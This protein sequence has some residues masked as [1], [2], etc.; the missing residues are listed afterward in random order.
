MSYKI[1]PISSSIAGQIRKTMVSPFGNLPAWS[2]LA[3]GYGPCRTCLKTFTVGEEERIYVT[4]NP[5]AEASNLPL[6][7]PIFIHTSDCLEYSDKGFP[8]ELLE[9]PMLLEGFGDNSQLVVTVSVETERVDEQIEEVLKTDQVNF[10][11][12]RNAEAGCFIAKIER[13]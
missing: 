4:Y 1:V 8:D 6:P 11:H 12:I 3:T 2:S 5:F 13:T 10:I 9:I 7:G